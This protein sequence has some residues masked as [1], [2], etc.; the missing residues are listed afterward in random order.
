[1]NRKKGGIFAFFLLPD[2]DTLQEVFGRA[3]PEQ[4]P[5]REQPPLE[6]ELEL[7]GL[8]KQEDEQRKKTPVKM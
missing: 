7:S 1:M 3:N 8:V 6:G 2:N 4:S 5:G